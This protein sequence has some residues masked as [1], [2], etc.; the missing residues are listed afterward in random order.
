MGKLNVVKETET[1]VIFGE[2]KKEYKPSMVH[3]PKSDDAIDIATANIF[4]KIEQMVADAKNGNYCTSVKVNTKEELRKEI[5]RCAYRTNSDVLDLS[6]IDV[7][8]VNDM[9]HLFN[10]A[11]EGIFEKC[12]S[13]YIE[14]PANNDEAQKLKEIFIKIIPN[15]NVIKSNVH[16][17][18]MSEYERQKW[19]SNDSVINMKCVGESKR[20]YYDTEEDNN[21]N[22][23]NLRI[24]QCRKV[25]S[26][27]DIDEYGVSIYDAV[28]SLSI[29]LA[30]QD[31]NEDFK[32]VNKFKVINISNWNINTNDLYCMFENLMNVDVIIMDN[33]TIEK[34]DNYIIDNMFA[35]TANLCEVSI[36]NMNS[37]LKDMIVKEFIICKYNFNEQ[38]NN[39]DELWEATFRKQYLGDY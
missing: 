27:I 9:R 28:S 33:V 16:R 18:I 12:L 4:N 35:N 36:K 5:L 29:L 19:M 10:F 14:R 1:S 7:S 21:C 31:F 39:L 24:N 34:K 17:V 20:K 30:S 6:H 8:A 2:P 37:G 11:D 3:K 23:F 32:Q 26:D 15:G 38:E 13:E 22:F 25:M